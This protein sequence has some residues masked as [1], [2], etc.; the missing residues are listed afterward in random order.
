M[1]YDMLYLYIFYKINKKNKIKYLY[2]I[3]Q[4][5]LDLIEYKIKLVVG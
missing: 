1:E 3:P 2:Y 4:F 5:I